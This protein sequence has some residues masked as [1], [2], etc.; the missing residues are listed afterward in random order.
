MSSRVAGVVA[1]LHVMMHNP[2][3]A[4]GR[5]TEIS[6][7]PTDD[8]QKHIRLL[9]LPMNVTRMCGPD[10]HE[11]GNG[12]WGVGGDYTADGGNKNKKFC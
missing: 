5:V 7:H 1:V 4:P 11:K 8:L 12:D 9:P 2:A 10:C 6:S 3:S